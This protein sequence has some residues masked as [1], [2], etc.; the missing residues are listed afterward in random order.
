MRVWRAPAGD[1]RGGFQGRLSASW[2][3]VEDPKVRTNEEFLVYTL[4]DLIPI[5]GTIFTRACGCS[6]RVRPRSGSF[7]AER[8]NLNLTQTSCLR[9]TAMTGAPRGL[10]T[11]RIGTQPSLTMTSSSRRGYKTSWR[12]RKDGEE[13]KA[14]IP[15]KM[16]AIRIL[17][18]WT[19]IF[20]T[21]HFINSKI[22]T[23]NS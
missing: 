17:Q 8:N 22:C 7:S 1:A 13:D 9:V 6:P 20:S 21:D 11:P 3:S 2:W 19:G 14:V 5:S 10:E 18:Q 16:E 4:L 23:Q 15:T 12:R